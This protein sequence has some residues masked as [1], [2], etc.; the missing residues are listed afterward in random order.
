MKRKIVLLFL[1]ILTIG[2]ASIDPASDD[3]YSKI[4]R[5]RTPMEDLEPNLRSAVLKGKSLMDDPG[6]GTNGLSCA[7]CHPNPELNSKWASIFPRRWSTPKNPQPRVITLNQ[8]NHGALRSMMEGDKDLED[9]AFTY[10]NAYLTWLADGSAIWEE[11][12]PGKYLLEESI[13]RGKKIFHEA[14]TEGNGKRCAD[15]HSEDSMDGVA[16]VF[17]KNSRRY[18]KVV[19]LDTFLKAHS[20]ETQNFVVDLDGQDLADMSAFLTDLSKGYVITL[21]KG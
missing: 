8:H 16:S 15:C 1:L 12:L 3:P 6:L 21:E 14:R 9:P 10:L 20:A 19:D 4:P 5:A 17:P 18:G 7:S 11:D 2:C 13:A